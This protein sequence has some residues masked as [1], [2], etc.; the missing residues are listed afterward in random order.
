MFLKTCADEMM[1][2]TG[3]PSMGK[4]QYSPYMQ[5]KYPWHGTVYSVEA[6]LGTL[7]GGPSSVKVNAEYARFRATYDHEEV[8]AEFRQW[9][10]KDGQERGIVGRL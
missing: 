4:K 5:T 8:V 9:L 3:G 1:V 6:R 10:V 2:G 7:L